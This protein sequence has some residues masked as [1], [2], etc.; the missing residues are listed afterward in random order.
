MNE[1]HPAVRNSAIVSSSAEGNDSVTSAPL[2]AGG[3]DGQRAELPE[4]RTIPRRSPMVRQ[5]ILAAELR[6]LRRD[7]GL[8]HLELAG[9]LGWQQGKV[10][11]IESAKQ[12]IGIDA[13]MAFT[14]VC[15]AS[16]EHRDQLLQHAHAA[17]E[18][19]WWA[20]YSDVLRTTDKTYL[21]MVTE[22]DRIHEFAVEVLPA[23]LRTSTYAD[24]V[25]R[26]ATTGR[27]P[28]PSAAE[29]R[30]E[31]LLLQQ[32]MLFDQRDAPECEFVLSESA[33]RREVGGADVMSAQLNHLRSLA[34]RSNVILRVLPY[35]T[36]A[37]PVEG[38]FSMIEF[39]ASPHPDLAFVPAVGG[40]VFVESPSEVE[41]YQESMRQLATCSLNPAESR[42][43]L[44][45]L[46]SGSGV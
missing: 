32:R 35:S 9:R 44:D 5:R 33:L 15:Q 29:R 40:G 23:P 43:Y 31:L 6:Q 3:S 1:T 18:R 38:A 4:P 13:V 17:R 25:L 20:D 21:G 22:A 46:S 10:S 24:S 19:A 11:K 7:A 41:L 30:L 39:R 34:G 14:E 2:A 28:E 27:A 16:P 8:T 36:G 12:S 37:L 45:V 42:N 26:A